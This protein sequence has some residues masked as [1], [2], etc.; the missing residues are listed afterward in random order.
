MV[1]SKRQTFTKAVLELQDGTQFEGF[2][3]GAEKTVT[4]ECVFQTG[5]VGYPESLT[6][7]SYRGQLLV[8]TYPMIGNYGV[9]PATLDPSTGLPLFFESEHIHASALLVSDYCDVPSHWNSVQTLSDW[10]KTEGVPALF[11]IDTRLL[12]K[13]IRDQGALLGKIVFGDAAVPFADPNLRNLVQE[14]STKKVKTYGSGDKTVVAFDCG[15]KFNQIRCLMKRGLRVI[16][17]PF[18]YDLSQLTESFDGVFISNGPGDPTMCRETIRQIQLLLQAPNPK[19]VF[20]ICLGNQLLALAAGAKT[21]KMKFGN[22]GHN[23]PCIDLTSNGRCHLTSQNHGF[24]VDTASLPQ[25]WL[26]LFVN[27]NDD[28]NEGIYHADKPFFSVQFHPEAKAGPTDTEYLFDRFAAL[29]RGV[30]FVNPS[31]PDIAH[32]KVDKVL[33]LGSGGLSIGQAGEFDYSGSQAIKALKQEG[34]TVVLINPN[35]A[36]VQT[37]TGLADKVY[38]LPLTPDFITRVLEIEKPDGILVTFGGQTALNC[39]IELFNRG[40]FERLG[41]RVLGTPIEAII[42]TEDREIFAQ[43]MS[44]IGERVAASAAARTV[45]EAVSVAESIGYPVILRAAFALGG[46]GSGFAANRDEL[47]KLATTAFASSEQ[48]LIE[49]SMKGWKEI[50]YEVVRDCKDNCITVTNMENFD[51][52]GVHT[53]ESIVVAPSQTLTDN[54]YFMLRNTAIKVIRSLGIVGECNIQYALNPYTEEYCII[55]VNARL[56]RSSALASKATGYPLAFVAAKLALGKELPALRN[57]VTKVT[58]ACFEP[59]LDYCVV[60]MPLWDLK[61]FERVITKIGTS[62]KSVGEVMSIGRNFEEAIQKAIRMV[63]GH[64]DGFQPGLA[65]VSEEELE[66]PSDQRIYVIASAFR[67][68]MS[69]DQV[70]DLTRIDKWFLHKLKRISDLEI[71]MEAFTT[72]TVPPTMLREA[73]QLGFSDKQIARCLTNT[74]LAVR[75]LRKELNIVPFVKQIDT[76]AAEV[77]AGNVNYLYMTYNGHE[78]DITFDDHGYIVIGSGAYRIGSSVEFDWCT[79]GAIS[80]LQKLGLKSIMINFNPETVSTDYDVC[81][82]LYFEELTMERVLD[83]YEME[84]SDGVIISMGGQIPNNLAMP[85]WRQNVNILGTSPEMIDS[86]ENRYKFSRLLD[87]LGVDQPKWKELTHADDIV[88]FCEDVGYP[89]LVRPSYV[90][91]G[92]AMNIVHNAHDLTT[93]LKEAT[94]VSRDHPVVVSKFIE[95]CKEIEMD[96]VAKDGELMLHC[97]SEHVENAGVHSGDATLVFPAQDLD[98]ETIRKVE[99]ATRKIARALNVSGP[100]NVQFLAKNNE[101][102][103]IECNLRASRSFP[104]V[105]KT[106]QYSLIELATRIILRAPVKAYPVDPKSV[107]IV[108]VKCAQFSFSRLRGADPVLRVEMSSTGEVACFGTNRY[109][110]FLKA[111]LSTGFKLPQKNIFLSIG[112]YREKLEFLPFAKLLLDMGFKLYGSSG[113]AD[114]ISSHDYPIKV[115]DWPEEATTSDTSAN[116]DDMLSGNNIHMCVICPSNNYRKSSA[117]ESRGYITRRKALDFNVPLITNIKFAKMLVHAL[118]SLAGREIPIGPADVRNARRVVVLPGLIDPHVHVRDPGQEHKEDWDTCTK[119]ALAGGITVIGAMPN[120]E[121]CVIDADAFAV[122]SR[123]AQAKARCDYGLFVGASNTNAVSLGP[124]AP[125]AFALKMYVDPTFTSLKLDNIGVWTEHFKRFPKDTLICCHAEGANL[126]GVVLLAQLTDR[127]V[128]ICHVARKDEIEIIRLAKEKGMR[129]TCEVAP[130]HLFLNDAD[131]ARLSKRAEVRPRLVTAADRQALWENMN[132]IDCFATDHAPHTVEEKD[133]PNPPPGFPGLET[134]L[135]LLLTAVHEGLLSIEDVVAKMY[136]NPKRIFNVPDQPN[137]FVEVD[138]DYPWTIPDAMPFSKC[139][140]TPFARRRVVGKVLRVVL[141]GEVAYLDGKV[142]VP[143]GFGRDI[144]S[145]PVTP[146]PTAAGETIVKPTAESALLPVESDSRGM[147]GSLSFGGAPARE[148]PRS[149]LKPSAAGRV[150][151]AEEPAKPP[152]PQFPLP[153]PVS[154][155]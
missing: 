90:L 49:K 123:A 65:P 71:S 60:K 124:L 92:A 149:P 94:A 88:N 46:L 43:R 117:F 136:T 2:S 104:F 24:A 23:Q 83:V 112:A 151:F 145:N 35:I 64:A 14:V 48:V 111:L 79:M 38:F 142:L 153:V 76:V 57:S 93:Y 85:L 20:G 67:E 13:K 98:E 113:T 39:G 70:H 6:D 128:H 147:A 15:M 1:E 34:V 81:D 130:H 41:V 116:I 47:V 133:G 62:M 127:P 19:P 53:G 33:L 119:A 96:A 17:V 68:G 105:S 138:L 144:R 143:R 16:V 21:Y 9:P 141:R 122:A 58:T 102:K 30:P 36:T 150:L 131:I 42:A 125:G 27:A 8:L 25:G 87:T 52:L 126:A 63:N 137:T 75:Q 5:M 106:I 120:T 22:R 12:T 7:P 3:F 84:S 72:A 66:H 129:V 28:S 82:R 135:P 54:E 110:A 155:S 107:K 146:V 37:T 99:E 101:I 50:E 26:P 100:F 109:E 115:L 55:E 69:V 121:P 4:G 10:L 118:Q 73:K 140:W 114:F 95:Y 11:G 18:D 45:P 91:S 148:A 86:A 80:T 77:S 132:I 152:A 74:E 97:I 51:P 29:I 139:G 32:G 40:V 78:H 56:S 31:A 59:S 134:I 44:D 89:V 103:V 108:G 154:V 61:K